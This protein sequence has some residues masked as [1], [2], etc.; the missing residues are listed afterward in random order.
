MP[1]RRL[2]S[3]SRSSGLGTPSCGWIRWSYSQL[4]SRPNSRLLMSSCSWRSF[5]ASTVS[6]ICC[7]V[8][9]IGWLYRSATREWMRSTV[10]ATLSS[11]SR[12]LAS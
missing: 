7:S 5:S 3:S 4:C 1:R 2:S 9:F 8:W 12:G 11:Y 6:R 10:W